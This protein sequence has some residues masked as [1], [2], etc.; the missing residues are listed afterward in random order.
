VPVA[1]FYERLGY[2]REGSTFL[3]ADIPHVRM[4]KPL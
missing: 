1:D 3:E 4:T 2:R